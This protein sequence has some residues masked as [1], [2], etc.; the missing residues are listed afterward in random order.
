MISRKNIEQRQLKTEVIT[1]D[2]GEQ[3]TVLE[4]P[5]ASRWVKIIDWF[6]GLPDERK[7]SGETDLEW[8]CRV[9]TSVLIEDGKYMFEE[10]E[11]NLLQDED[12][13]PELV[14]KVMVKL[15]GTGTGNEGEA[16][17][18]G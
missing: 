16:G 11:W 17:K 5:S 6:A 1:L 3:V 8:R 13:V 15:T 10:D 9:A 18:E 7:N 14:G 4:K 2:N 12:W